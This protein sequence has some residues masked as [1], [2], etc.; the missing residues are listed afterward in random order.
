MIRR[1]AKYERSVA[2]ISVM[3]CCWWRC[4]S[5]SVSSSVDG[6]LTSDGSDSVAD[7]GDAMVVVVG[8]SV[9]LLLVVVVVDTVRV[10]LLSDNEY[11]AV[12]SFDVDDDV[13][14][15]DDVDDDVDVV[16]VVDVTELQDWCGVVVVVVVA[17]ATAVVVV[18]DREILADVERSNCNADTCESLT[19]VSGTGGL[20]GTECR[21]LVLLLSL[22]EVA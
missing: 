17:T 9:L 1:S 21:C 16:V 2:T 11:A 7:F 22:L 13:D 18:L 3:T 15:V 8:G 12:V 14:D 10:R 19:G 6:A 5:L 4:I 20:P